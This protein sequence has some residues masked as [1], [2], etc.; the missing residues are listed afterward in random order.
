MQNISPHEAKLHANAIRRCNLFVFIKGAF[1]VLHPGTT[2]SKDNYIETL[3]FEL[4]EAAT[5]DGGRLIITMPPRYL[6]SKAISDAATADAS[7]GAR[8]SLVRRK[9]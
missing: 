6:K 3:C 4:Q 8:L 5:T 9:P 2:L 1:A 7:T